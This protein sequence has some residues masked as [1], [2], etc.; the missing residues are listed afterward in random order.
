MV[1]IIYQ[2]PFIP[3]VSTNIVAENPK[4]SPLIIGLWR[5]RVSSSPE[6]APEQLATF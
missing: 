3:N 6:P 1:D 4:V 2:L 5:G